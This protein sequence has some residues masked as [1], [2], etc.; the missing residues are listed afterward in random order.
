ML[1]SK[2]TTYQVALCRVIHALHLADL[3]NKVRTCQQFAIVDKPVDV[4]GGNAYTHM[5]NKRLPV[6][7]EEVASAPVARRLTCLSR[8][9]NH[10]SGPGKV[11][12][13]SLR[14]LTGCRRWHLCQGMVRPQHPCSAD[15]QGSQEGGE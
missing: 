9:P 5:S 13:R 2:S 6:V 1:L 12:A 8:Y 10:M 14:R 15:S 7:Q 3:Q 4:M 11:C